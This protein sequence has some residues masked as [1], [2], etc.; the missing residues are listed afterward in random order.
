MTSD[1]LDLLERNLSRARDEHVSALLTVLNESI[2][3]IRPERRATVQESLK[4]FEKETFRALK[5]YIVQARL[6][7]LS[8]IEGTNICF[9]SED[10]PAVMA[11]VEKYV[12]PSLYL[13]RF[14][15]YETAVARHLARFGNPFQ[16]SNFRP[17]LTKATYEVGTINVIR[18]FLAA[19]SDDLEVIAQKQRNSSTLASSVQ[20]GKLEQANRL[21]KLEPNLFGIGVNLNYLIR[22]LLGRRE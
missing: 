6:V 1:I 15:A 4:L 17:D 13:V 8:V 21:I 19:L 22:R 18:S 9:T 11:L 12:K 16:L 20:E 14:T 7:A 10:K 2:S 5:D 3:V